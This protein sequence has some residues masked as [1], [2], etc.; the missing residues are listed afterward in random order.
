MAATA[1]GS[2]SAPAMAPATGSGSSA[3]SR[4]KPS[5]GKSR[6][7]GPRCGVIA[8][9]AASWTIIA[10]LEPSVTVAARFVIDDTIGTWSSSCSE[11]DP[12]RP[13]GRPAAEH[14]DRRPVEPGGGEGRDPVGD[15]RPGG[16]DGQ[17]RRPVQLGV[18][19]RGERRRL[20][21]AGVD[22][23]HALVARGLVEGP[24]VAAVQREHHVHAE[25]TQSGQWPAHRH[26]RSSCAREQPCR[27]RPPEARPSAGEVAGRVAERLMGVAAPVP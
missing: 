3:S 14:H 11:P 23:A 22:D 4:P 17:P 2:G 13:C 18:G 25:G 7:T 16:E 12:H 1:S 5:N 26:D 15:A 20:L 24:D 9:A 21:V 10:A 8:R 19:L 27:P 6:K